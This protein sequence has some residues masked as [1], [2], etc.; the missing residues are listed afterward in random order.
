[1]LHVVDELK[2][3]LKVMEDVAN[4]PAPKKSVDDKAYAVC[5][6]L[7]DFPSSQL[8]RYAAKS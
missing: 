4:R 3:Q 6:N 5:S 7:L 1:M 8:Y 2:S